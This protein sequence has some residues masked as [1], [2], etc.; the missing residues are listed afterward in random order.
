MFDRITKKTAFYAAGGAIGAAVLEFVMELTPLRTLT[1]EVHVALWFGVTALGLSIGLITAQHVYFKRMPR[2]ATLPKPLAIGLICGAIAGG[3]AQ[4]IFSVAQNMGFALPV[5][6]VIQAL[7]WGLAG[8]GV[9]LGVSFFVPNYPR[10]RALLAGFAGGAIGG[11][12]FLLLGA[13][14]ILPEDAARVIGVAILGAAIGLTI[15]AVEEILR[16]AWLTVIW[17]KNET[18]SISLGE[19]P[20]I[21]GSAPEAIVHLP[22]DKFP[23]VTAI[24]TVRNGRVTMDNKLNHQ[25]VD[26]PNGSKI[27]FG[28]ISILINTRKSGADRKKS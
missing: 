17:A 23:P 10:G 26:L 24:L 16:E 14:D 19:K 7:C 12:A 15:S 11:A 20:V 5:I 25:T 4:F 9:G 2:R 18:T 22:S 1:G 27:N 8:L 21:L 3:V 13:F 6:R 28:K